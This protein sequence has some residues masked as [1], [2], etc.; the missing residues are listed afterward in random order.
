MF[1]LDLCLNRQIEKQ[2]LNSQNQGRIYTSL[3]K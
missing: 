3:I 1:K 2:N